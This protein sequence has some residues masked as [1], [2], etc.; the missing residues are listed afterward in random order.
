MGVWGWG[1]VMSKQKQ[2]RINKETD[3][4]T[5]LFVLGTLETR[6]FVIPELMVSLVCQK[7]RGQFTVFSE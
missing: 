1:E 6:S 2:L 3:L 4:H 5:S 7:Q